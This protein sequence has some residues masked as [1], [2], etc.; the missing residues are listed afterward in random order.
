MGQV[1]L[2]MVIYNQIKNSIIWSE[3]KTFYDGS[4]NIRYGNILSNIKFHKLVFESPIANPICKKTSSI[5]G[6]IK[7]DS[8]I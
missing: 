2:Y 3:I 7:F 8:E 5:F 4:S 1:N 6:P